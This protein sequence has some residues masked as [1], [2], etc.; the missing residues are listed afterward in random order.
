MCGVSS[1][2]L[3]GWILTLRYSDSL[4]YEDI[5]SFYDIDYVFFFKVAF[6]IYNFLAWK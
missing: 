3:G 6:N 1:E 5:Y 2:R 4:I